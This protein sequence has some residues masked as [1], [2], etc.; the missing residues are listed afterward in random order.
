MVK[1]KLY[2]N[3]FWL[4]FF[5]GVLNLF[6]T[7]LYLYW[8]SSWFDLLMHFL[9]GFWVA[10]VVVSL[11]AVFNKNKIVY[12]KIFSVILWVTVV[13]VLWEIF[14]LSIGATEL[15]DGIRFIADTLSDIVMDIIGGL[16]GTKYSYYLMNLKNKNG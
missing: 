8:T 7:Y 2:R 11:W 9:G 12:P 10:M 14:E 13:G 5:I 6:A 16:V 4:L 1:N 15:S 3:T